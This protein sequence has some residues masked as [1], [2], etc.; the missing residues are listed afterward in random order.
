MIALPPFQASKKKPLRLCAKLDPKI[1]HQQPIR[2]GTSPNPKKRGD[3][4][5]RCEKILS[6]RAQLPQYQ[7]KP[8]QQPS[9]TEH[10]NPKKRAFFEICPRKNLPHQ[11]TT[12][13]S[14]TPPPKQPNDPIGK[15]SPL[16]NHVNHEKTSHRQAPSQEVTT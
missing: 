10:P 1:P 9:N 6:L 2:S 16:K 15:N 5:I 14:L 4:Q 12:G 8:H 7:Q 11:L 13:H 3:F